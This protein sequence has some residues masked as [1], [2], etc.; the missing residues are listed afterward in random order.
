MSKKT[1]YLILVLIAC[2]LALQGCN[3]SR[4]LESRPSG[5]TGSQTESPTASSQTTGT[6]S[7][8]SP[9]GFEPTE[10]PLFD[11]YTIPSSWPR[12]VPLMTEFQV[13]LYEQTD[14]TMHAKG[15]AR[16]E[17][18]RARNFYTNALKKHVSSN[19]W[20]QDPAKPSGQEGKKTYFNYI[21]ENNTLSVLLEEEADGY[22]VF[23]LNF[24]KGEPVATKPAASETTAKETVQTVTTQVTG[25]DVDLADFLI[26]SWMLETE[27]RTGK[28]PV[29]VIF[30]D[31]TLESNTATP[32]PLD[33]PST[34][35][36]GSWQLGEGIDGDWET[37]GDILE[38][39]YPTAADQSFST[40]AT[41]LDEDRIMFEHEGE[42]VN[43][44]R[45]PVS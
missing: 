43:Y 22:L 13:T 21:G 40:S 11:F 23:E 6:S 32:G 34:W 1:L 10:K 4:L 37:Q 38:V 17:I 31:G 33:S 42:I 36:G 12:V 15:Y 9:S 24:S 41:A 5:T 35:L 27:S 45:L 44:Q 39:N 16:V 7:E 29:L 19:I 3:L 30:F 20:E 8:A 14:T 2:S 28:R 25:L 18:V 26:G